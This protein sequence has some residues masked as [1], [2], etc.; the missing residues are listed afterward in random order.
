MMYP[1]ARD[2][3]RI[4]MSALRAE[5]FLTL[6]LPRPFS[7]TRAQPR[8]ELTRAGHALPGVVPV[9]PADQPDPPRRTA[10]HH[11]HEQGTPDVDGMLEEG[12]PRVT[13]T[14]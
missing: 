10:G 6:E 5:A 1:A 7:R 14:A 9:H 13:L 8:H 2:L 11:A 3:P 12:S 4:G